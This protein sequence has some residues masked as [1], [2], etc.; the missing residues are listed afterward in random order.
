MVELPDPVSCLVVAAVWAAELLL[1]EPESEPQPAATAAQNLAVAGRTWLMATSWPQ[2]LTTSAVAAAVIFCWLSLVHWH[3][4]SVAPQV[5]AEETALR[6][7]FWAHDGMMLW[8]QAAAETAPAAA[9]M[10]AATT[11]I[12]DK[13][14]FGE[15]V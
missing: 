9:R 14:L 3:L 6:I 8:S 11:F 4:K 1:D 2:D 10:I 12:V 15:V 5:V 13:C 7:G